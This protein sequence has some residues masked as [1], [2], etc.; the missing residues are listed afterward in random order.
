MGFEQEV[1]VVSEG[2]G[3]VEVCVVLTSPLNV[4]IERSF[5]VNIVV[6]NGTAEGT[7]SPSWIVSF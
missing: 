7:Y 4:E 1:Y 2:D 5:S 6:I 3:S